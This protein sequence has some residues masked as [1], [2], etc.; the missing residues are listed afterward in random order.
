MGKFRPAILLGAAVI[1]ALIT[2]YLIYS[3]IQ[4]RTGV[5]K[6][7][8]LETQPIAV[9]TVDLNWGTV[10]V[11]EMVKMEE[12]LK[13]SDCLYTDPELYPVQSNYRVQSR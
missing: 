11:K 3:S 12:F 6:A 1:I 8:I 7:P 9:V 4:K 10:V 5:A 13:T 2:T